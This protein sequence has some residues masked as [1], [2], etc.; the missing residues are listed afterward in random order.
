M[1]KLDTHVRFWRFV[2]MPPEPNGCWLWIGT[3]LR[4]GYGI[5]YFRGN[6]RVRAHRMSY[7]LHFGEFDESMDVLHSCDNPSCVKPSHLYLGTHAQNM[8]DRDAK[9][10]QARGRRNGSAKLTDDDVRLIRK[11]RTTG[12]THP[13]LAAN[14]GVT[15]QTIAALLNGK[16]WRSIA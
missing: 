14:Y 4:S 5:F 10:R 15:K 7:R 9:G 11:L 12:L 13:Q 16:T 3:K 1:R 2:S 8:T 6:V